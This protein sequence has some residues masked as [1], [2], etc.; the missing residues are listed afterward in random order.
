VVVAVALVARRDEAARRRGER[1][2][3]SARVGM[4]GVWRRHRRTQ[5][6]ERSLERRRREGQSEGEK[7]KFGSPRRGGVGLLLLVDQQ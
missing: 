4:P 5:Q 3:I 2:V 7:K 1:P 6:G